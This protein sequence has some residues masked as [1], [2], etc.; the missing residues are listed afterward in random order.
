MVPACLAWVT[1]NLSR[2]GS[3]QVFGGRDSTGDRDRAIRRLEDVAVR[4]DARELDAPEERGAD[5]DRLGAA[6]T[7]TGLR[8]QRFE[9][10]ERNGVRDSGTRLSAFVTFAGPGTDPD[11]LKSGE[12]SIVASGGF[13]S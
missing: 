8:D 13:L 9:R 2:T 3:G 1:G 5:R 4:I 7:G 6:R 11:P 10:I 12:P